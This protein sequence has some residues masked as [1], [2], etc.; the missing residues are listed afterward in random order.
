[1]SNRHDAIYAIVAR[2]GRILRVVQAPPQEGWT[3]AEYEVFAQ[4]LTRAWCEMFWNRVEHV[5]FCAGSD[6]DEIRKSLQKGGFAKAEAFDD[7]QEIDSEEFDA[8][9]A[10]KLK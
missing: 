6:L 10:G 2:K 4:K 9:I 8:V 5:I 7:V 1:M 3:V